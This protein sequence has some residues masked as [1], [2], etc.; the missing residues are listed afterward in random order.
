MRVN[1]Y[2]VFENVLNEKAVEFALLHLF[3]RL[4]EGPIFGEKNPYFNHFSAKQ[5]FE[6]ARLH[7]IRNIFSSN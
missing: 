2:H 4:L 5:R 7:P 6:S 3:C 1:H